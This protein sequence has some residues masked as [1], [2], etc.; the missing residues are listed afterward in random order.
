MSDAD[1]LEAAWETWL[2]GY[3]TLMSRVSED[4]VIVRMSVRRKAEE[5]YK[6]VFEAGFWAGRRTP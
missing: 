5:F 1:E 3:M 2:V 6:P 4:P